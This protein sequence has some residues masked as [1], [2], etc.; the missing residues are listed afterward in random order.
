MVSRLALVLLVSCGGDPNDPKYPTALCS[1]L[2]APPSDP[3]VL[4]DE[5][6]R[7]QLFA[8]ERDA[9]RS[10]KCDETRHAL[11]PLDDKHD[12]EEATL[13]KECD[14]AAR[15]D[16]ACRAGCFAERK[17]DA[18]VAGW[19]RAL[20][21]VRAFAPPIDWAKFESECHGDP[22]RCKGLPPL[23]K[24][25]EVTAQRRWATVYYGSMA[26]S[27]TIGLD[28][29]KVSLTDNGRTREL[30]FTECRPSRW[31]AFYTVGR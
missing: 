20:R 12:L 8:D 30:T 3:S 31:D 9:W 13:K 19:A 6:W 14:A 11:R 10:P 1:D 22:F 21:N 25:F 24:R 27:K 15:G 5:D 2:H 16:L 26:S 23:P 29:V 17:H 28:A 4:V 7:E 18:L